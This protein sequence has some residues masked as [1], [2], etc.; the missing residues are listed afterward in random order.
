MDSYSSKTAKG[1]EF[2]LTVS[3]TNRSGYTLTIPCF[4]VHDAEATETSVA[5]HGACLQTTRSY[6]VPGAGAKPVRPGVPI[7]PE[8]KAWLDEVAAAKLAAA[9]QAE[10]DVRSGRVPITVSYHDGEYLSGHTCH[11]LQAQLLTALGVAHH[12]DGWGTHVDS[13]LVAALG[14]TFTYPDAAAFVAPAIAAKQAATKD[15]ADKRDAVFAEAASTGQR[16]EL[17]RHMDECDGRAVDC[18]WDSVVTYAMPDGT[19]RTVRA[20]TF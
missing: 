20:H 16:R 19:T 9:A 18:S 14:E 4:G 5:G 2:T 12:V 11:G 6:K 17:S 3:E 8:V 7:T 1:T 13:K 10:D 15:A